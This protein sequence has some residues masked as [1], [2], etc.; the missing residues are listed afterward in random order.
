MNFF[1][2]AEMKFSDQVEERLKKI[3]PQDVWLFRLL[4]ERGSSKVS[5]ATRLFRVMTAEEKDI[6]NKI[7]PPK[8]NGMDP[9]LMQDLIKSGTC[10]EKWFTF[11][12]PDLE[13]DGQPT[14]RDFNPYVFKAT[15]EINNPKGREGYGF[16]MAV[17]L[18]HQAKTIL[19]NTMIPEGVR[20]KGI[21]KRIKD[22]S[23]R[24]KYENGNCTLGLP[25]T[26]LQQ[27]APNMTIEHLGAHLVPHDGN[28]PSAKRPLDAHLAPHDG[29]EPSAKRPRRS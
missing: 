11:D 7:S 25:L 6:W 19:N 15:Q 16:V 13:S 20:L 17:T 22:N 26:V 28:K 23:T 1:D 5:S 24:C 12:R 10:P 9:N 18:R 29:N 8:S 27:M 4:Y 21:S 14:P 3:R 2:P